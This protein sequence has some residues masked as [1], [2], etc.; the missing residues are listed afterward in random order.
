MG[1]FEPGDQ[2]TLPHLRPLD[3]ASVLAQTINVRERIL[4]NPPSPRLRRASLG[5]TGEAARLRGGEI[6][7]AGRTRTFNLVINRRVGFDSTRG[8]ASLGVVSEG[9]IYK[10]FTHD[11]PS[12]I[13]RETPAY[14]GATWD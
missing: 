9:F 5:M 12:V 6:G 1:G 14:F 10:G 4:D 2:F 3:N 11:R 7:S 8:A 13:P